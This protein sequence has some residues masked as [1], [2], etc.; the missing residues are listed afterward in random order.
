MNNRKRQ[1]GKTREAILRKAHQLFSENGFLSVSTA[2]I[3]E[4]TGISHGAV[5]AH[6]PCR[7]DLI[8][9][10]IER[11][12]HAV[13]QRMHD[14]AEAGGSLRSMLEAHLRCLGENE[15]FYVH[16]LRDLYELPPRARLHVIAVQSGV[17]FHISKAAETEMR[18][19]KIK[20]IAPDLLFNTWLGLVHHYLINREIFTAKGSVIEAYGKKLTDHFLNLLSC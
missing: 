1:K 12:G 10:V 15:S 13:V 14:L 20:S 3:A 11:F 2:S 8:T 16:L 6:F 7:D 19:A 9:A 17:S 18:G 4:K 5:F